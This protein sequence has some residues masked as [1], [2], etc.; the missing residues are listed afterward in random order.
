M[1]SKNR[2][3][4]LY[5]QMERTLQIGKPGMLNSIGELLRDQMAV[6]L[7]VFGLESEWLPVGLQSEGCVESHL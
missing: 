1:G 3:C 7:G 2:R 6:L 5:Q 4:E